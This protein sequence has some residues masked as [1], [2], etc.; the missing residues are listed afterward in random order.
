MKMLDLFSG[1]G[2]FSLAASWLGVETVGFVEIDPW[3]QKVLAKNFPGVP[4]HGDIKTFDGRSY[5][6]VDLITGGFPCQPFSAAGRRTG[7]DDPRYLWPEML[8]VIGE[9][10]PSYVVVENSPRIRTMALDDIWDGLEAHGYAVRAIDIP[11]GALGAP[12]RRHRMWTL[13]YADRLRELQP[14]GSQQE[15]RG[16][17]QD[18]VDTGDANSGG[19]CRRPPEGTVCAGRNGVIPLLGRPPGPGVVGRVHGIPKRV[20]RVAGLGNAIV[21]Q[22]AYEIL[23]VMLEGEL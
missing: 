9:S 15:L 7:K 17:T 10:R 12:H 6:G 4:I 21:P 2:G 3:C 22:V 5:A 8:R 18:G 1:I 19:R 11:A 23:R 13:A 20:D 14:G 16:W